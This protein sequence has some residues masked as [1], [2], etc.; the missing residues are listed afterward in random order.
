MTAPVSAAHDPISVLI[1]DFENR[2]GDPM[3][4]GVVEQA[5]GLGIEGASFINSFS[6]RDAMRAAEAIKPG[7]KLDEQTSRLVAFRENLGLA[8]VGAVEPKG[9]GY[10]ITIKGVGPGPDGETKFTLEDDAA[11]KADVLQTVGALAGAGAHG[12]RRHGRA[13]RVRCVHGGESRSGARVREG[14]GAVRGRQAGRGDSGLHRRDQARSGFRPR[15]LERGD[16][17][18]QSRP[19]RRRR[20]VLQAG[21]GE[22]RSHDGAREA[23]HARPVLPVLA[24]RAEGDR[25][26]H[27]A[28]RQVSV[29]RASA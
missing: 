29:R 15:L 21:A 28:R 17:G 25:G 8:V 4:D 19:A 3:F 24:Q 18:Q 27:G 10:H 16:G 6:R 23:P 14:A 12:A 11:N 2:T 5:L 22:D 26:I 7:S 20:R 9:S 13:G 1:G